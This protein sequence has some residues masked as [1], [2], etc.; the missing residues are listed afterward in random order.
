[1]LGKRIVAEPVS[2]DGVP[3][4][5]ELVAARLEAMR[6][7]DLPVVLAGQVGRSGGTLV[8]RLF[9][10]HPEC[11]VIPHELGRMLPAKALP[12]DPDEAFMRLTPKFLG[13][14]HRDGVK[15]GKPPLAVDEGTP[16]QPFH[17][18]LSV[19]RRLFV[20]AMRS[21]PPATDRDVLNRYFSAYFAA[22]LD[23]PS[24]TGRS[25]IIGFEPGAIE[26]EG[27]MACFDVNYPD[28]RV[29]ATIR[30]PWSWMVSARAWNVRFEQRDVAMRSWLRSTRAAIAR[31]TARP[32]DTLLL[33]F[34]DLVLRTETAMRRAVAFLGIAFNQA[35]IVP[36]LNG[37]PAQSNSSFRDGST[38]ALS[39]A[40]A[41]HRREMLSTSDDD[42]IA[43]RAS[44]VWDDACALLSVS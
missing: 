12:R 19:L 31:K 11:L 9:D 36:S 10:A 3:V 32:N 18:Q 22:W 21:A 34:E 28:G 26:K 40:P 13:L 8:L 5:E 38:N 35:L 15:V 25:W 41:V 43:E 27:S 14:W 29:L 37:M 1:M 24:P 2:S 23:G 16:M 44:G 20:D 33:S 30:D 7:V 4:D 17:L 6:S 42:W 39:V